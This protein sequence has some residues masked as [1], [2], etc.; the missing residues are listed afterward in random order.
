MEERF[1]EM[2][3]KMEKLIEGLGKITDQRELN[4]VAQSLFS[5]GLLKTAVSMPSSIENNK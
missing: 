3:S 4:T 1:D 5:S 2:Q